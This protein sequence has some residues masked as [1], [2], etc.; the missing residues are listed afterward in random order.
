MTRLHPVRVPSIILLA[1]AVALV[2]AATAAAETKVGEGTS[3]V[4]LS[5]ENGEADLLSGTAS[6]DAATGAMSF[7]LTTRVAPGSTPP[8]ETEVENGEMGPSVQYGAALIDPNFACTTAD[9]EAENAKAQKA[10]GEGKEFALPAIYPA[11][12]VYTVNR[13]AA[14]L[15]YEAYWR[16]VSNE[17]EALSG[18]STKETS[19]TAT[20]SVSGATLTTSFTAPTAVNG[21]YTCVL[22]QAMSNGAS[23][24]E[25]DSLLF[26]LVPKPAVSVP[27]P[28]PVLPT[29]TA[30]FSL[31]KIKP[32]KAK[33]GK[34]TKVKVKFTNTG[35]AAAGPTVVKLKAPKGVVLQPASGA[36][37]IP[38]LAAGQSW[39]LTFKAKLTEKA[40]KSS[41]IAVTA[42]SGA[43]SSS[44]SFVLELL[45]AKKH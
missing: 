1:L 36:L 3:P 10:A 7:S 19:G 35:T 20:R 32:L 28:V 27:T 23:E 24:P 26:P 45:Q 8:T 33:V 11:V 34:W 14:G 2:V 16:A 5:I 18:V 21:P 42:S 4:N 43:V 15:P 17:A 12:V 41:K 40:K 44:S 22:V 13:L 30:A 29:P 25:T 9:W 6:F 31:A 38:S 39:T 37:K